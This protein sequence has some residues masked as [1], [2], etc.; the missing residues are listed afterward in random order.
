MEEQAAT[1][2][3]PLGASA[4]KSPSRYERGELA[5]L[6]APAAAAAA[7]GVATTFQ[8]QPTA[9]ARPDELEL[10]LAAP[11]LDGHVPPRRAA[12]L[13]EMV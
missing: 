5:A 8:S 2:G 9:T 11:D 1:Y 13:R 10:L 7:V 3:T 6:S 12:H 4:A